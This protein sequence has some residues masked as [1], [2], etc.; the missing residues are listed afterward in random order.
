[1]TLTKEWLETQLDFMYEKVLTNLTTFETLVPADVSKDYVYPAVESRD[2]TDGFWSGILNLANEFRPNQKIE[3]V[4]NSQLAVFQERLDKEIVLRHHD[5]GFL[6]VPSAVAKYK[7]THDQNAKQM[8]LQAAE[9]LMRRYQ[10]QAK[11]IQAWG[12]LADVNQQGRM[13]IDCN[14]NLSLLY[15]ASTVSGNLAY[16]KAAYNHVKNAQKYLVREDASTYHTY[17]MDI[18]TGQP[19]Y[20]ATAQ[21][22]SDTSCWSRGQAWAIYG[23]PLS[24]KYTRDETLLETAKK[25]ADYFIDHCPKDHVCYWDL[26]FTTGP[27][28]RDTSAAAIA[29]SGLLELAQCLPVTDPKRRAYEDFSQ[30][31]LKSLGENYTTKNYPESNGFLTQSVYSKPGNNGVDECSTWGDYF[32]F[33]AILR[34]YQSWVSY[35]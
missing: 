30:E 13:I 34:T 17:Y 12:D 8:A 2:W 4:I 14:M 22:Y 26:I 33:E 32:Y 27:E 29:A 6:Y 15:F 9:V 25:T 28:E 24:Y 35:W 31:I 1:M 5:L 10:V 7:T 20:G 11:I 16:Y 19:R 23:F 21:G 3:K 18:K